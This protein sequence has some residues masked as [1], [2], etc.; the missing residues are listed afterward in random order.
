MFVGYQILISKL[1]Y[2]T[3]S[4]GSHSHIRSTLKSPPFGIPGL[5][6][7]FD[8]R[9]WMK[10]SRHLSAV[11]YHR[12]RR[13]PPLSH[14][15]YSQS[16]VHS[17]KSP[18]ISVPVMK[19]TT[20]TFLRDSIIQEHKQWFAQIPIMQCKHLHAIC[21]LMSLNAP[22]LFLKVTF[23]DMSHRQIDAQASESISRAI[24]YSAEHWF[25][26]INCIQKKSVRA[27]FE[28]DFE[29]WAAQKC[30]A[31]QFDWVWDGVRCVSW[32]QM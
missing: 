32:C 16:A 21:T 17:F 13:I 3:C 6:P 4:C 24:P 29:V 11:Y 26:H 19:R 28:Q 9:A 7:I 12:H 31:Q 2:L 18:F 25:N 8:E 27:T 15:I 1:V 10:T 14:V 23:N 30:W 5:S 20:I 22:S